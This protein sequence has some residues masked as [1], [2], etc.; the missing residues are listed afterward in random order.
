MKKKLIIFRVIGN[1]T[2]GLGHVY[3]GLSILK[4]LNKLNYNIKFIT[5]NKNILARQI[6]LKKNLKCM[7]SSRLNIIK[8]IVGQKPDLVINDILNTSKSDVYPLKQNNIKVINFEDLGKGIK[9]ADLVINELY[10][11]PIIKYNN[12]VWGHKYAL[13][14]EEFFNIKPKKFPKK[15]KSVLITFGGTD[16]KSITRK[17]L[18]HIYDYCN[19]ANIFIN[20][21]TGP[22]YLKYSELQNMVLEKNMKNISLT[23]STNVISKYML[24]SDIAICSNGR[25]VHELA[26]LNITSIVISQHNR[27]L[28]H[29]F[30]NPKNGVI[31]IGKYDKIKTKRLLLQSFTN[32][33][34]KKDFRFKLYKKLQKIKFNNRKRV[35]KLISNLCNEYQ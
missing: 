10:E 19:V 20:I 9:Y 25:T 30:S 8:N 11:N 18:E 33:V 3:R 31:S 5:D 26:H 13:L 27:E 14:R 7:I 15:V 34:Q 24:K 28:T 1:K 21:V 2:V 17:T 12:I 29:N 32:L 4:E 35:V 16:N 6:L 22:G 23:H